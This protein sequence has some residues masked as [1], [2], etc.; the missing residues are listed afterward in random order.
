VDG[1]V[2]GWQSLLAYRP[3]P[4]S[5]WAYSSTYISKQNRAKGVGLALVGFATTHAA[6]TGISHIEAVIR[7]QNKAAIRIGESLGWK[8]VGEVPESADAD[9]VEVVYVYAAPATS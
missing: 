5:T 2:V 7:I 1:V 6:S 8:R 9:P 3:S 4:I